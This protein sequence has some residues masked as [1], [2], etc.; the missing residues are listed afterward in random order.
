LL[1]FDISAKVSPTLEASMATMNAKELGT[2]LVELCRAHKN[3]ESINTL[4]A[5]NI[6]SVEA[7]APPGG[8]RVVKGLEGVRAKSKWWADNHVVHSAEVSGPYPHGDDR[9]AVRFVYDITHK[10]SNQR[11]KM[12]EVAVF[13][14][15]NGKVVR[16]EF[17]YQ[18]M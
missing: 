4:Y 12:D 13:Y 15:E 14:V 6:V 9:F 16:E 1:A 7:G 3:D 17:F 2:K 5:D 11:M 8:E 18:G 10:P